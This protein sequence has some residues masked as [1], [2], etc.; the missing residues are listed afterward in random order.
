MHAEDLAML[1]VGN[2]LHEALVLSDDAG[3]RVGGEGKLANLNLVA[4]L[5]GPGFCEAD[6]ADFGVA[7][8]RI[9]Y[10]QHVNWLYRFSGDVRDRDDAFHGSGVRELRVSQ[11]DVADGINAGLSGLHELVGSDEAAIDLN[12]RLLEANALGIRSAT[13]R[14]E[15]LFG[16]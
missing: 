1:G 6:T 9:R 15:H 5:F 10:A 16:L 13:D 8:G 2:N 3:A 12:L 4:Q 7:V 11:H 14:E